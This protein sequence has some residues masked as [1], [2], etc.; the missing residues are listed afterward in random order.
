MK[1]YLIKNKKQSTFWS[2]SLGWVNFESASHFSEEEKQNIH[3]LPIDGIWITI[4]AVNS[5]KLLHKEEKYY[6]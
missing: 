1:K 6:E 2:N 4:W 5:I 3:Y